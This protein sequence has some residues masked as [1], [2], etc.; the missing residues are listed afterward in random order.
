MNDALG[1]AVSDGWQLHSAHTLPAAG[2]RD[3][4]VVFVFE[5]ELQVLP[6]GIGFDKVIR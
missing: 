5:R 3:A 2:P 4:V 6:K 1:A